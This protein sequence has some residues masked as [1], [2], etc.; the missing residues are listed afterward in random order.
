MASPVPPGTA[1][2]N[3][4]T[5]SAAI[6]SAASQ[7][8][9]ERFDLIVVGGGHA[10]CEAALTAARLGLPATTANPTRGRRARVRREPAEGRSTILRG[11]APAMEGGRLVRQSRKSG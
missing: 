3:A 11:L 1:P 5:A 9:S 2:S 7:A 8:S 4:G 10:G 6:S